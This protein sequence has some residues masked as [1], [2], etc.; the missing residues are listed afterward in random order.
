MKLV[1]RSLIIRENRKPNILDSRWV[2]KRKIESDNSI[3][4]KARLVKEVLRIIYAPMSRLPLTQT[5]LAI[6]NK[7]DFHICQ[8][9]VKTVL[10][11]KVQLQSEVYMEIPEGIE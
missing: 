6:A 11:L 10:F 7:C 3:R 9:D 4:Y 5:I 8:M 1:G 2:L